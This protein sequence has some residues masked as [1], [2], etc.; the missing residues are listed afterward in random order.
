LFLAVAALKSD[1][2][3]SWLASH[4]HSIGTKAQGLQPS[5][6]SAYARAAL[7]RTYT[8]NRLNIPAPGLLANDKWDCPDGTL[9]LS[10]PSM[11]ANGLLAIDPKDGSFSYISSTTPSEWQQHSHALPYIRMPARVKAALLLSVCT[12]LLCCPFV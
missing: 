3:Q 9:T 5:T 8:S 10:G 11:T 1:I 2:A 6:L 12:A 7:C 4:A